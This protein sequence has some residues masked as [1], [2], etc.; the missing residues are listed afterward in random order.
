VGAFYSIALLITTNKVSRLARV[1]IVADR[2]DL[3]A[4]V[5]VSLQ[6]HGFV[7]TE[8]NDVRRTVS[9]F[10]KEVPEIVVLDYDTLGKKCLEVASHILTIRPSTRL[11]VLAAPIDDLEDMERIGVD[12]L[13]IK[14]FP[15]ERLLESA[16]ALSKIRAPLKIVAR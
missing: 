8:S 6:R 11:I 3:H 2:K 4:T 16:L 10:A 7:V 5:S 15:L 13:L 12:V 1:L 14:P 9:A